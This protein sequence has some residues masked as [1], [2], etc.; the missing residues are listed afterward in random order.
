MLMALI[1]A[2]TANHTFQM[3]QVIDVNIINVSSCSAVDWV[4]SSKEAAS[5]GQVIKKS[6]ISTQVTL[7]LR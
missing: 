6:F 2:S 4:I 3:D 1:L 7:A 5:V